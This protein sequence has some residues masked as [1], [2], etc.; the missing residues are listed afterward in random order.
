MITT[1]ERQSTETAPRS[2]W[3]HSCTAQCPNPCPAAGCVATPETDTV[4]SPEMTGATL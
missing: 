1:L 4:V 2:E 3:N